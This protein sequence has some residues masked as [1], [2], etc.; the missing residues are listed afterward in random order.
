M[1]KTFLFVLLLTGAAFA[2]E[3]PDPRLQKIAE[4]REVLLLQKQ[5]AQMALRLIA[6]DLKTL[7]AAEAKIK[8]E[9]TKT[10]KK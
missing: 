5:N 6:I 8:A 2:A 1:M 7:E 9:A 3:P 4:Q 10:E